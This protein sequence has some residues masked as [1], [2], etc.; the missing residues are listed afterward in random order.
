MATGVDGPLGLA[1][2]LERSSWILALFS[3]LPM[4]DPR[5]GDFL[6]IRLSMIAERF[7][8]SYVNAGAC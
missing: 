6:F 4:E 3:G 1:L 2:M 8:M 7:K 5:C